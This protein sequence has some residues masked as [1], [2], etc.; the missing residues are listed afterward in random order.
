[1]D[2]MT[3]LERWALLCLFF[4]LLAG[5]AAGNLWAQVYS[6]S[7]TG[8]VTDPSGA[9]VPGAKV[10]LTD[11]GKK[12]DYPATTDNSGRYLI[13]P[14]P[15]STYNLTVEAKGFSKYLQNNVVLAVNQN[16]SVDVALTVG[17]ESQTIEVIAATAA[18][19]AT[20]DAATGQELD[21]NMIN[22]LPLLGRGVYDLATLAPGVHGRDGGG[23]GGIN[24]ISNGSRNQTADILMDGVSATSF[25]QNSGILDV[26]Y[27]PSV[28]SVQEFKIQQSNFSAEIGFSGSTIINMV[29]RSGSNQYHGSAWEFVRNNILRA[30][31]WYGNATGTPQ[32]PRRYNQ[33]GG[34]FGGP[35]KKDK[36]FFFFS[37]EGTRDINAGT[38]TAG[39][40]SEAMRSGNFGEICVE[41]FD[42]NG[43]CKGNGQIWDPYSGV[44]DENAG[45]VVHNSF[46]P[47]NRM[48]LYQSPGNPNLDG[49]N[50]QLAA[51]PGNLI[52]PVASKI[53]T[54]FPKPNYRLG[55]ADYNRFENWLSAG[56]SS[57]RNDQFDIKIDH[58]FNDNNRISAKFS[59]AVGQNT[60]AQP[61]G[62]LLDPVGNYGNV[63]TH[64]FAVNYTRT[65]SANTLLNLSY[66]F[67]RRF[68]DYKDA[69]L[70]QAKE[71]GMPE[72]M[73]RSGFITSPAIVIDNYYSAGPNNNIG[74]IP[75][76]ILRQS[77]ETHH[78]IGSLNRLHGRH[79]LKMGGEGRMHRINF[80]QPGEEAGFFDFGRG[81]TSMSPGTQG[82]SMATFLTGV[83]NWGEYEIPIWMSTQSFQFSGF[84][85][86]N[87]KVTDK[88]T[89]NLGLRYDLETPRTERY[90]R[91]SYIDPNATN[92]LSG[93]VPGFSNLT[94]VLAFAENNNRHNWGWDK[95]NWGPRFGFAYKVMEK[96]VV[97]GGYGI[98][99][100]IT[101]RG[102][103][104]SGAYGTSGFDRYTGMQTTYQWDGVTP[105]ARLHD[106]FP[107]GGPLLPPGSSLG[108]MSFVGEGIRGPIKGMDA[109][110]YEQSWTFGFQHELPGGIIL[111]SN[112]VGK[113]GTK[114]YFGGASELNHLGPEFEKYAKE[115][116]TYASQ[117]ADL[118]T[119]VDNPF[120][121]HVPDSA[122]ISGPQVQAYQL[123]LPHPQF[124]GLNGIAFPVA[125][126]I[127]H[128]FQIRAEKR[129]SHGLQFS[130]NYTFSKSIDNASVTHDGV[131]W[132]GGHISLQD[133]N[134]YALERSV[135]EFDLP[136]V[137][138]V[139]YVYHLP[140]GR[141]QAFGKNWHPVLDAV[142]GGWKSNGIW[143]FS[144]G[145]PLSVYLA[146]GF[147][148][149]TYGGQRPNL[150]RPLVRNTGSN[151]KEQYF[152][153]PYDSI[154]Q[155]EPYSIGNAPRSL[156]SVRAPGQ[157]NADLSLLKE[158]SLGKIREGM[159]IEVRAEFFNAFNHPIFG[160]PDT[161]L[162]LD[163]APEERTLGRVTSQANSPREV[164]MA[165]KIYW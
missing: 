105:G 153:N 111:D 137:F 143:R 41:G 107:D 62:N 53:M 58:S 1:M 25:E 44:Y 104:G 90:N 7:L 69:E 15:P 80:T 130:T 99:Y 24:F 3:R 96:T 74:A 20:Q 18:Q 161:T 116:G 40:P 127:Y 49:T 98:F 124:T 26:L 30:N 43:Q 135:S 141:G 5:F 77:P 28:D 42:G 55:Q 93:Q 2:S 102:A 114:L 75:W 48:D 17:K 45:G 87:W 54:Y 92:P 136:H 140:F 101:S 144:S 73:K 123:L 115:P 112:Y 119:Y 72:Y 64:M 65:F 129:F 61:F 57:G 4:F 14:L 91:M 10:T 82:D 50:L 27:T 56:S 11:A 134:N 35:I 59:R 157:K 162:N 81:E 46:I 150:A 21:R 118:I 63:H 97:R 164:Q 89:V 108:G 128:A 139:S 29:T 138:N 142:L 88:L 79:E 8:V 145:F 22:E 23:G 133:P 121:G 37:Y 103:A 32:A 131:T 19:L 106:P 83:V 67:S 33:F 163:L 84:F 120:Y 151:W 146:S 6:G 117:I 66:G 132:L 71:L 68:D 109:T 39:V 148:L 94:G 100:Q 16:A 126:S 165:L 159:R 149:P 160:G 156:D 34:T 51:H 60:P 31:S 147:S 9:V 85:Q 78:L 125:N 122:S 158:F 152:V 155:P 52:D 38:Y 76:G 36:T 95:N 12:F 113:K 154:V 70:D 13:R 86:D 110:P 47:F